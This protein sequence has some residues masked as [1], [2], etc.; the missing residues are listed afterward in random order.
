MATILVVD[1]LAANR[2]VLVL[3]LRYR[4]HVLVEA[5][6][7]REALEAVRARRPDLVI[8]DVLMPVMDGY[9]FTRQLRLDPATRD[10]PVVFYTAH[11]G[12]REAR[13]LAL[14]SGV[15]DVLTKPV[16]PDEVLR[17]VD[18]LLVGGS[19]PSIPPDAYPLTPEFDREHLQLLTDKLSNKTRDLETANARLSALVN[20][21]LELAS[22]KDPARLLRQVCVAAR[23]LFGASYV[24]IGI[25][26]WE[27]GALERFVADGV[28]VEPW[29]AP[30]DTATGILDT[31]IGER[32][33]L[34][35]ENPGGDPARLGL[36]PGHPA[37]QAYLVAPIASPTHVYG[38]ICFAGNEGR[39]FSQDDEPLVMA[40]SG[41]VGRTYENGYFYQVAEW[42]RDRTQR[43]LDTA[44]V[45]L[46]ALDTGG[47]ITQIN[48]YAC[49]MLGWTAEEL[50]GRD[51]IDICLPERI[52][53]A[54]RQ[55]LD[56]L[57]RGDTSI[58]E[59]P[60]ISRTGEERL[61]E[62][63]NTL[64]RDEAGNV[65]GVVSCGTDITERH[66]AVEAVR[67]AE[68]RMRFALQN[69]NVGIWDMDYVT[70][71]LRWSETIEAHYGLAPGR[72]P[73]TFE[74]FVECIHPDDRAAVLETV[75][76]AMKS[77]DDFTTQNRA[78]WP[79][80]T[81]RWL[82]GAG[83]IMLG[84]NDKPVRGVGISL[85]VTERH[86]LEAQFQQ[87]QKMEAVGRLA[88]GVAHDF[89]N[90]LT[91]ILG[92]C[93]LL[94]GEVPA[95]APYRADIA[96]IQNAGI[97]A[98]GL[99]RQLLAFSRKQIIEPTQL[100]LSAIVR[101]MGPMLKRL[102]GEDV[103]V[104]LHL[105]PAPGPV[106]ADRGQVEQVVMNLAVNSRDAMPR[107]GTLTIETATV[108]LDE[109]YAR[110]H[111]GVEPGPYV[112]LTVTDSGTGMSPEVKSR[113]F[114]PFFTTK[115]I[116]KGTGLGLATVHGIVTGIGGS[117]GVYSELGLGTAF[118]VYF[119][120][121]GAAESGAESR[122]A[123]APPR[124]GTQTVLVVEDEAPLRAL[125]R[126]L[127]EKLGYTVLVASDA[128]DAL[129]IFEAEA[130]IDVVLTDV[131]MPGASGP[132]LTRSLGERRPDLTVIY[133][134]G[135]TEEAIVHHGVLAPGVAFLHKPFTSETLGRKIR[136]A[137]KR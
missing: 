117:I 43:Y 28:A 38:W 72:F 50:L 98:A 20:I 36:P 73:G 25:L 27:N 91:G 111:L 71:V 126:R 45:I 24:T 19:G 17:V 63:R 46:L 109:H 55:K 105:A 99:T 77:G 67:V 112:V 61:I 103:E 80:G 31:A 95:D 23:D 66:R 89:N 26:D 22:E 48:R 56:N 5:G 127:L 78:V 136:E 83:R 75:A 94:L 119:P 2:E 52:R 82:T 86:I 39:A 81:V 68:E 123:E 16:E 134:S 129:R 33:I 122:P 59:N 64:L 14:S 49:A 42:E 96:E 137:L 90:L 58:V 11:Y 116:G 35:G 124:P 92:Y 130:S 87:A 41:Q 120:Q 88:G 106:L 70:G 12:E 84:A 69:A 51:W 108:A 21:G 4:G 34:R 6:D 79:D 118:K 132:E 85:D 29:M 9:E 15:S 13:A 37:I 121:A 47:R 62:W 53:P 57:V 10:L 1:D 30:G 97:R 131:V 101:E 76:N 125:T 128:A 44:E 114:E 93:E 102:I 104:V 65:T 40:L 115:E 54:L 74:A 100:D 135:Y 107:G 3:L 7:G 133:M 18:R 60:V 32:R 110:G 113:L 8:T